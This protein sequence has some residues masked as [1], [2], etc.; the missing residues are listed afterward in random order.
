MSQ[1]PGLNLKK[2]REKDND[3]DHLGKP[4]GGKNGV[5]ISAFKCGAALK[6]WF[7]FRKR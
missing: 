5:A 6:K 1:F 4:F 3:A 7:C 2:A